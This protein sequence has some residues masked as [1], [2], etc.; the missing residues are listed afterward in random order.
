MGFLDKFKKS[1]QLKEHSLS[2]DSIKKIHAKISKL[3]KQFES[4]PENI[5][6]L[7]DLYENYVEISNISK[8]IECMEKLSKLRPND[9][10][11]LQQLADLY[12][13]E[14]GDMDKANYYQE[15][16]NKIKKFF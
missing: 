16:A 15:K 6:L 1:L 2:S 3:E 13:N 14:L 12:S 9:S 11:P 5:H 4:N 7:F 8:K 10:Y